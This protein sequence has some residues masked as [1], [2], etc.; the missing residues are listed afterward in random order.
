[1]YYHISIV[2]KTL[3]SY[4]EIITVQSHDRSSTYSI[5]KTQLENKER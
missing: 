2:N 4:V 1:M 5:M 3:V